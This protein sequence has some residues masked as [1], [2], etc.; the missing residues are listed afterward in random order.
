M[1]RFWIMRHTKTLPYSYCQPAPQRHA[2]EV[3]GGAYGVVTRAQHGAVA[4]DGDRCHRDVILGDELV[5]TLVLTQIPH[6]HGA[7]AVA[8]DQLALVWVYDNVV[9]GTAVVVVSLHAATPRVPDLDCAV[10]G[11]CNHPLAL[12]VEGN[13]RD[14][15]GVALKG[16]HGGRVGGLDVVK[17]DCVVPRGGEVTLVGR[18]AKAID[19]RVRVWNG[20]GADACADT[21][22]SGFR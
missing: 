11:R 4:G 2:G 12:A 9:D 19:L 6:A 18:D 17:L 8:A 13:A 1:S 22:V 5:A 7:R 14:I 15:A 10:L 16:E 21:L 3:L 20:S